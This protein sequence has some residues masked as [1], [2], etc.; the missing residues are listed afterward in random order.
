[1]RFIQKLRQPKLAVIVGL[2]L[3]GASLVALPLALSKRDS[4]PQLA[5]PPDDP[6]RGLIYT[7]LVPAPQGSPCEGLF[8]GKSSSPDACTHGPDPTP[9]GVDVTHDVPPL[10]AAKKPAATPVVTT[11]PKPAVTTGPTPSRTSSQSTGVTPVPAAT[12]NVAPATV[13]P[14]GVVCEGDGSA[15]SRVQVIYA[16]PSDTASRYETYVDSFRTWTAGADAIIAA[17]AA[18]TGGRR[19]I[20]L[21]TT[22]DCEVDVIQQQLA[23][24]DFASFPAIQTALMARG[25]IR[26][27]RKYLVFADAKVICGQAGMSLDSS[28]AQQNGNNRGP[29]FARV[30]A[31]CWG[32]ATAAHELGHAFGAVQK[33]APHAAGAHCWDEPDIMCYETSQ[34]PQPPGV[35]QLMCPLSTADTFDCGHDDYFNTSTVPGSYVDTHWNVA[36]SDFLIR[37]ADTGGGTYRPTPP[38]LASFKAASGSAPCTADTAAEHAFDNA[39]SGGWCSNAALRWLQ[40]DLGERR[41]VRSFVIRNQGTWDHR[42]DQN[43]RDYDILL[44][45][46]GTSWTT[47]VRGRGNTADVINITTPSTMPARYVRL[48]VFAG[49]QGGGGKARVREFLVFDEDTGGMMPA[50]PPPD[51]NVALWRSATASGST[52]NPAEQP[53]YA[54]DGA[55]GSAWV[56]GWAPQWLQVDFGRTYTVT[57]FVV[58][59][60]SAG[61]GKPE[62]NLRDYDISISTDGSTWTTAVQV[63]GNSA[64]VVTSTLSSPMSARY[65]R[66]TVTWGEQ[67]NR[68]MARVYHFEAHASDATGDYPIPGP[69]QPSPTSQ[70]PSP[71]PSTVGPTSTTQPPAPTSSPAPTAANRALGRVANASGACSSGQAASYA[72]DGGART[73]WCSPGPMPWLQVDL[74]GT[75]PISSFVIRHASSGGEPANL[76]TR[77]FDLSLST[78]GTTWTTPIRMRG[79]TSAVSTFTLNAAIPARYVKLSVLAGEQ[80]GNATARIYELEAYED[81]LGGAPPP[82]GPFNQALGQP[83]SATGTACSS[84]E[85][86]GK[87]VDNSLASKWCAK[88]SNIYLQVDLGA[89]YALQRITVRHAGAGGESATYNTRDYD[90]LT[91]TDGT[92]WTTAAQMSGNTEAITT[93]NFSIAVTARYVRLNIMRPEQGTGGAARIYE[94]EAYG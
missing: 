92:T 77:D 27:D 24:A 72:M 11:G 91:S 67:V 8:V 16:Y 34:I 75:Y 69:L 17:S 25:Y 62:L 54:L 94:L 5:V 61:G 6:T 74:G 84:A 9:D 7:D 65:A 52:S 13:G 89:L 21:V 32:A 79:N 56:S 46:D 66:I 39:S 49:E 1:V 57:K 14:Q 68:G 22:A 3:L 85:T 78:D 45:A 42:S 80:N 31:G 81:D 59:Q 48:H 28:P 38:N 29:S 50:A 64:G 87:A 73:K 19:N 41:D 44:S 15:G 83:T 40:V 47:A 37:G 90:I 33:S 70:P 55:P 2:T 63:R 26:T 58:G 76:N 4:N 23:P 12:A 86:P 30:D 71:A 53:E 82:T 88:G 10:P 43:T 60:S 20:R 51:T 36:N 18:E 35:T 93:H